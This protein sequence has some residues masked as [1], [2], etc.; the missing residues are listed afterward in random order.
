MQHLASLNTCYEDGKG[1]KCFV[2]GAALEK[3][4]ALA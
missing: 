2:V 1:F 3:A 4:F